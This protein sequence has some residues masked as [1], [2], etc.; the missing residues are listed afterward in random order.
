MIRIC[1]VLMGKPLPDL[2]AEASWCEAAGL[3]GL[4]YPDYQGPADAGA[5]FPDLS[6]TLR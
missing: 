6:V 4:W 5:P 3:D 1:W 2:G